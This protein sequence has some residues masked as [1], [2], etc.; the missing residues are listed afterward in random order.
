MRPQDVRV[1]MIV[2]VWEV[3][4]DSKKWFIGQTFLVKGIIYQDSQ[5]YVLSEPCW[6]NTLSNGITV[7]S[8]EPIKSEL[9]KVTDN[10]KKEIGG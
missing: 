8:V 3:P 9:E 6:N 7:R 1:D 2:E 4:K 5:W 10:I